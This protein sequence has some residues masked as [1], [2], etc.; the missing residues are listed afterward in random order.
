MISTPLLW[1]EVEK[2]SRSRREPNLSVEPKALLER[3]EDR[4]DL[5]APLL[6]LTQELPELS[7]EAIG[8]DLHL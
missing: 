3:V 7:T 2:A 4:G 8:V 5:F 1:E 6:T